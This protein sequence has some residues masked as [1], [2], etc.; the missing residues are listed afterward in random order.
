MH[1]AWSF[2]FPGGQ[3]D[4][5]AGGKNCMGHIFGGWNLMSS[6]LKTAG[7][8]A[9]PCICGHTMFGVL[10]PGPKVCAACGSDC[11]PFSSGW[12]S[13]RLC[14]WLIDSILQTSILLVFT[15]IWRWPVSN[16]RPQ[17]PRGFSVLVKTEQS[18]R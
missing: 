11:L 7:W 16:P 4:L 15:K 17:Q 13:H 1:P 6:Q 8:M 9:T 18:R 12:F 10:L 5:W 3:C 14:W 2:S